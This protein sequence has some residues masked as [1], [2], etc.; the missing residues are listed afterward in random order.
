MN[1][2]VGELTALGPSVDAEL[3]KRIEIWIAAP[4]EGDPT[5][6][7]ETEGVVASDALDRLEGN[8][9]PLRVAVTRWE[10]SPPYYP[11]AFLA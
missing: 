7:V 8:G 10:L 2:L 5:G 3:R 1:E 4:G 6:S 11:S 9:L